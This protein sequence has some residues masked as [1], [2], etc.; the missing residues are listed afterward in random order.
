MPLFQGLATGAT[1][2]LA[3][4]QTPDVIIPAASRLF[5]LDARSKTIESGVDALVDLFG[6]N[7]VVNATDAAQ[8]AWSDSGGPFARPVVVFDGTNDRLDKAAAATVGTNDFDLFV[9]LRID[10]WIDGAEAVTLQDAGGT[11]YLIFRT[12]AGPNRWVA[13]TNQAAIR[14]SST[15]AAA[16]GSYVL[17][18][19]RRTN[20]GGG[21]LTVG[22]SINGEAETVL[23]ATGTIAD[24]TA[25]NLGGGTFTSMSFVAAVCAKGTLSVAQRIALT[26]YF[27]REFGQS[28]A[29][30]TA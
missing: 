2:D 16:A 24:V 27:N 21:N 18:R 29:E 4:T 8:P 14:P 26:R 11:N 10:S 30:P 9:L 20:P 1:L 22:I 23:T 5:W 15:T 25:I 12:L 6:L 28:F 13:Y 3:V 7:N 17:A 19:V